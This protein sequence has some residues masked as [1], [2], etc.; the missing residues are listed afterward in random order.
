MEILKLIWKDKPNNK[1][2]YEECE[3][4]EDIRAILIS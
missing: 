3:Y 4:E 2:D 1:D